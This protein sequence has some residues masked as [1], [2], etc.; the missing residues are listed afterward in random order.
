MTL[1]IGLAIALAVIASGCRSKGTAAPAP[2]DPTSATSATTG[3]EIAMVD[4]TVVVKD[5]PDSAKLD[6]GAV[7]K[8]LRKLVDG[9]TGVPGGAAHFSATLLPSGRIELAAPD[10]NVAAG[11][12]PTCVLKNPLVHKLPLK[13][14]C[15]TDVAVEEKNVPR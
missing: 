3:V 13:S 1:R 6:P 15:H 12:V 4:A 5:C 11:V 14:A 9:C 10:G 8:T 2:A 7:A